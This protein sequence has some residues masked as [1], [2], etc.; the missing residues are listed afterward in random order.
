MTNFERFEACKHTQESIELE[1]EPC[2][3][4]GCQDC[5]HFTPSLSDDIVQTYINI[6]MYGPDSLCAKMI[7]WA[8]EVKRLEVKGEK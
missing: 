7:S 4:V 6:R 2:N 3:P 1:V 5:R 8:E